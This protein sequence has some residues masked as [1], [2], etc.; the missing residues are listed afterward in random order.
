V[1]IYFLSAIVLHHLVHSLTGS[2]SGLV[3]VASTLVSA[4]LAQPLR[5]RLQAVIDQ[6]FYRRQ[7]DAGQALTAL[8]ERLRDEVDL[9]RMT[10]QVVGL[11]DETMQPT[12]VVLW[13]RPSAGR[14]ERD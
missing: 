11:V 7:Y 3:V 13:L 14:R 12:R 8:T 2:E 6:R 5:G 9:G 1:T 4:A 10:D